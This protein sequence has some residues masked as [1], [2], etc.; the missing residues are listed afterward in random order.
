MVAADQGTALSAEEQLRLQNLHNNVYYGGEYFFRQYELGL[1]D[2]DTWE[3]VVQ[4]FTPRSSLLA[5]VLIEGWRSRQGPLA[6]RFLAYLESRQL[7]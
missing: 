6:R 4:N 3:N 1:L 7:L 5:S 2:A